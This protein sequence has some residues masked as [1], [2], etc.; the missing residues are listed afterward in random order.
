[1]CFA[2]SASAGCAADDNASLAS[3]D[4]TA[5]TAAIKGKWT[6]ETTCLNPRLCSPVTIELATTGVGTIKIMYPDDVGIYWATGTWKIASSAGGVVKA[7]L[8]V[9]GSGETTYETYNLEGDAQDLQVVTPAGKQ[10]RLG[11]P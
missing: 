4:V 7:T 2:L 8:K 11:R 5:S 10:W 9:K 6:G 3:D 1:M